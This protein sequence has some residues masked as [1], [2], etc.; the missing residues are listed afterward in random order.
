[1]SGRR[2]SRIFFDVTSD[3]VWRHVSGLLSCNNA[4]DSWCFA[5]GRIIN[6]MIFRHV[7]EG[8]RFARA[9]NARRIEDD[10]F[11]RGAFTGDKRP[12]SVIAI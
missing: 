4:V 3:F 6:I 12:F 1:V 9:S 8:R 5:I 2:T 10:D 7:N 11:L